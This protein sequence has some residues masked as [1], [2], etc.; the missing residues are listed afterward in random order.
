MEVIIDAHSVTALLV[1]SKS[2]QGPYFICIT[3]APPLL[4]LQ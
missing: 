2:E 4:S 1:R 3:P